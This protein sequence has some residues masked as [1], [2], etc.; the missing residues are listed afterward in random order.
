VLAV[1]ALL[2]VMAD[3]NMGQIAV[4]RGDGQYGYRLTRNFVHRIVIEEMERRKTASRKVRVKLSAPVR[5]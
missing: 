5:P 4:S 1:L 3:M 2:C